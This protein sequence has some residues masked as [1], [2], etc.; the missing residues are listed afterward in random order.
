MATD[1]VAAVDC[2]TNST[3]LLVVDADGEPV[4]RLMRITRLGEGVDATRRLAPDAIDRT[5][6]ALA[7]FRQVMENHDVRRGRLVA[8]SAARDADN[9][10]DFFSRVE[11]VVGL[12]PEL[13]SGPEEARLSFR[14]ATKR[15]PPDVASLPMVL[16][17]DIGGGSTELALGRPGAGSGI[18][19]VSLDIGCVRLTE[20]YLHGD[21]PPA[22][23]LASAR[24]AVVKMVQDARRRM[25]PLTDGGPVVGLAGTVSMLAALAHQVERYDRSALHHSV[26]SADEV[27]Q[28]LRQLA[29]M[30]AAERLQLP[31]MVSGRHDI[32]VGG[33][34][35]LA[36]VMEVFSRRRCLVSED[37]ILDGLV[38]TVP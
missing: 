31:G 12:K 11:E 15:L 28:W 25:P 26:L 6:A 30:S 8:T 18:T 32:I 34:L 7:E 5:L 14:G 27:E 13:L 20:R 19:A 33:A 24:A 36:A 1:A 9:A 4:C 3:R 23:Q 38:A 16:V 17:C 37:D 35:I 22:P 29:T 21:P 2:G 10:D